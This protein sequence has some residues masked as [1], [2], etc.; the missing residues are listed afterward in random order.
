MAFDSTIA[1]T[2]PPHGVT[3]MEIFHFKEDA[4]RPLHSSLLLAAPKI[5]GLIAKTLADLNARA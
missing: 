5:A 2:P 4:A 1:I 3:E